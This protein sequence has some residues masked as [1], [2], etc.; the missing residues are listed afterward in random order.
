M[1]P[2]LSPDHVLVL[3]GEEV[4]GCPLKRQTLLRA[5]QGGARQRPVRDDIQ[6]K[7]LAGSQH[8]YQA[9]LVADLSPSFSCLLAGSAQRKLLAN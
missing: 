3:V 6:S 7:L 5:A 4:N 2:L 1:P 8:E 9:L